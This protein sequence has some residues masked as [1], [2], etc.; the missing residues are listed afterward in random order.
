VFPE[1][2]ESNTRDKPHHP[3]VGTK[4]NEIFNYRNR[5]L[6]NS[7]DDRV[8]K[9]ILR[10]SYYRFFMKHRWND[11]AKRSTRFIE[12]IPFVHRCLNAVDH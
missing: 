7:M 11:M 12:V 4:I 6:T 9:A 1:A 2:V 10:N 8:T 3:L 5:I